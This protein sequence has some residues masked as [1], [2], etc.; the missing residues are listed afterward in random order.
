MRIV[1]FADGAQS[2]TTPVIGNIKAS[3]L[4]EYPDDATYEATEQGAP[5]EGNLYFNTTIKQIRYYNGTSWITL[6]DQD[7]TQDVNNKTLVNNTIDADN[8]T[9]TNIDNDEIKAGAGIDV[10]KLHDGSV[11]NT[12]FGYLDGV[13]SSIQ[14]QLDAKQNLSEKGA[15]NGYAPLDANQMVPLANLPTESLDNVDEFADFASLP[16]SGVADRL[17]VTVDTGAIYRWSGSMY[18][19]VG[20]TVKQLSDLSDADVSGGVDNQG[21]VLQSGTW[22]PANV[23][24]S[25]NSLTGAVNLGIDNLSDVDTST[26]PPNTN[27]VLSW[28]GSNWVPAA[29]ANSQTVVTR[30]TSGT[31]LDSEDFVLCDVSGGTITVTLPTAAGN[32]GKEITLKKTSDDFNPVTISTTAS[33]TI[34]GNISSSLNTLNEVLV[35]VSDDS[36]WVIKDR[37]IPSVWTAY[38]PTVTGITAGGGTATITG[39]WRR[40]GDSVE[41]QVAALMTNSSTSS[42]ACSFAVP[43]GLTV[44]ATRIAVGFSLTGLN[45]AT[46]FNIASAPGFDTAASYW[47][48]GSSR[49]QFLEQGSGSVLLGNDFTT[50]D[51]IAAYAIAP[52]QGWNG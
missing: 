40:S 46:S 32:E 39:F 26:M 48:P 7:T 41:I 17:Y 47:V 35:L 28:D 11:D 3:A 36:N 6:I 18:V 25:V 43:A 51:E 10:T 45:S 34:D 5:Q 42:T 2:E 14:T 1:D 16:A 24:N 9:I 31:I 23:V 22:Q 20:S 38:T 44:D 12:E 19:E 29:Q 27:E 15:A 37:K 30:S 50:N 33:Q 8:N 4:I 52:V 21:L 13:T 49:I